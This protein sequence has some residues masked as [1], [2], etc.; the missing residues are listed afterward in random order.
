MFRLASSSMSARA[1]AAAT[2]GACRFTAS[3][4]ASAMAPNLSASAS[5]V[6]GSLS[7]KP[8]QETFQVWGGTEHGPMNLVATFTERDRAERYAAERKSTHDADR[9]GNSNVP[10]RDFY[11]VADGETNVPPQQRS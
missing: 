4:P 11:V 1:A 5:K 8:P 2:L 7:D 9:D 10:S 3:P 6:S